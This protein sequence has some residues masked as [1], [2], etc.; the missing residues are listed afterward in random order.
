MIVVGAGVEGSATA[1]TLT[2]T[3]KRNILLLEQVREK[4]GKRRERERERG[5][6]S[7]CTLFLYCSLTEVILEG[8]HLEARVLQGG[9]IM[10]AIMSK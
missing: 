6:E 1:Y 7:K 3:G 8:A 4:E 5:K 9:H 2:S 10:K